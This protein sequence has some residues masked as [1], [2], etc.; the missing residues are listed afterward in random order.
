MSRD[1]ILKHE[2]N[3]DIKKDY[4][5]LESVEINGVQKYR[6][7]AIMHMLSKKYYLSPGTISNIVLSE[8]VPVN[9]TR[10]FEE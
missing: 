5:R 3:N 4:K 10:L 9:Q 7:E 8:D 6:R 2:R 1:P